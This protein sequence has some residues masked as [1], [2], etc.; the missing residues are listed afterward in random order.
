MCKINGEI[1]LYAGLV[2]YIYVLSGLRV[3]FLE[4]KT[5]LCTEP[6]LDTPLIFFTQLFYRGGS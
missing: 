4:C 5:A 3:L 6:N 2:L 1:C